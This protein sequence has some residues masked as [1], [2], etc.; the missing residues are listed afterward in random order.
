MRRTLL[1]LM[2][3]ALTGC[4]QSLSPGQARTLAVDHWREHGLSMD[5]LKIC[6]EGFSTHSAQCRAAAECLLP[7]VPRRTL[8]VWGDYHQDPIDQ[9]ILGFPAFEV[10]NVRVQNLTNSMQ[11]GVAVGTV[12]R[13]H[14]ELAVSVAP[15]SELASHVSCPGFARLAGAISAPVIF[16]ADYTGQQ[17]TTG[18]SVRVDWTIGTLYAQAP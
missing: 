17:R 2:A 18:S 8:E 16:S 14:A 5:D 3:V 7:A 15:S 9:I 13:E 6:G 11:E 1:I 4:G 10:T 12:V